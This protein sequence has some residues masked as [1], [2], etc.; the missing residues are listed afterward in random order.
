M[1]FVS[2]GVLHTALKARNRELEWGA[3]R[4]EI[5]LGGNALMGALA[6]QMLSPRYMHTA[7]YQALSQVAANA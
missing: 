7:Q 5:Q 3:S 1:F 2:R 6:V 4:P